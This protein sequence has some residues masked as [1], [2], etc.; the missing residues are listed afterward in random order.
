MM[1]LHRVLP[2]KRILMVGANNV[3]FIVSSQLLRAGA[4]VAA[5]VEVTDRICGYGVHMRK[6]LRAGIPE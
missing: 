2:G 1:N 3:G 6:L 5:I 4:K